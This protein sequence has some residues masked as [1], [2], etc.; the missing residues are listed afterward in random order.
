M[1]DRRGF[2]GASVAGGLGAVAAASGCAPEGDS[3][4]AGAG[5]MA[6]ATAVPPFELD[7]VTVD[8]LQASMASGERTA[9][10]IAEMYLERI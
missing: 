10:S 2:I 9:R 7:E 8:Q 1:M 3:A 5:E 6:G 4:G